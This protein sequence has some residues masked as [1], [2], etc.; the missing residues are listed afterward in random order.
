MLL[1]RRG[2]CLCLQSSAS[3]KSMRVLNFESVYFFIFYFFRVRV[4]VRV[5]VSFVV[6]SRLILL[7]RLEF[8]L[9]LFLSCASV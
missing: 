2:L 3:L 1:K 8:V 7:F 5:K 9:D 6:V 4:K